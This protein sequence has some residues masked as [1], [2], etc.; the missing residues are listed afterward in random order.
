[1]S[2]PPATITVFVDPLEKNHVPRPFGL[3]PALAAGLAYMAALLT[4]TVLSTLKVDPWIVSCSNVMA[5]LIPAA[6]VLY[7]YSKPVNILRANKKWLDGFHAGLR[8][9]TG[10]HSYMANSTEFMIAM[11][12]GEPV[13]AELSIRGA[14]KTYD[15]AI[16]GDEVVLFS[17]SDIDREWAMFNA[18]MG[19]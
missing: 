10:E 15:V 9:E 13:E 19:H 6:V 16:S 3:H 14:R 1:M 8:L 18:E 4:S 17:V 12:K 7:C 2:Q 11:R 5:L